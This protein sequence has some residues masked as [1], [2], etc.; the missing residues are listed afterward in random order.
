M[1]VSSFKAGAAQTHEGGSETR[2]RGE[3]DGEERV[4]GS[5]TLCLPR[6]D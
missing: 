1:A 5:L 4:L 6:R 2:A 3:T